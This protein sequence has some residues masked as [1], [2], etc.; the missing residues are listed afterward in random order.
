MS[1]TL[2]IGNLTADTSQQDLQ[3]LLAPHQPTRIRLIKDPKTQVSRGYAFATFKH[4]E[5]AMQALKACQGMSLKGHNLRLSPARP[6]KQTTST[7]RRR[8]QFK[9]W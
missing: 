2:Y 9:G 8:G 7:T 5:G 1:V 4:A 6:P 3:A